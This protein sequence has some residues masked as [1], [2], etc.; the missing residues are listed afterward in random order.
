M[1]MWQIHTPHCEYQGCRQHLWGKWSPLNYTVNNSGAQ[2]Q[3]T[4]QATTTLTLHQEYFYVSFYKAPH[5]CLD[6]P[7]PE[8]PSSLK[9]EINV[10]LCSPNDTMHI[11]GFHNYLRNK[12][13]QWNSKVSWRNRQKSV[14]EGLPEEVDLSRDLVVRKQTPKP[15]RKTACFHRSFLYPLENNLQ[16]PRH[17]IRLPCRD[18]LELKKQWQPISYPLNKQNMQLSFQ[19]GI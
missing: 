7:T 4:S 14:Q 15:R 3:L 6:A 5:L 8:I 16:S 18:K 12:P 11:L 9:G 10:D 13:P 2:N 17:P 1:S 19:R